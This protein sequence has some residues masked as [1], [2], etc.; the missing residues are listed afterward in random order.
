MTKTNYE[1]ELERERMRKLK[2]ELIKASED[3]DWE[4]AH[5]D[6]NED[7]FRVMGGKEF[8]ENKFKE[9]GIEWQQLK[10]KEKKERS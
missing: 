5:D 9:Y 7:G 3:N 1:K 8:I 10:E 4:Y 2:Q 6:G